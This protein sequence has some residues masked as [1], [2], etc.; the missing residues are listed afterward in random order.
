MF[1]A[2]LPEFPAIREINAKPKGQAA[3]LASQRLSARGAAD[4]EQIG[5]TGKAHA[6][7]H[8]D[9]RPDDYYQINLRSHG[10]V[11]PA[12]GNPYPNR[13]VAGPI[14]DRDSVASETIR[15]PR[16]TLWQHCPEPDRPQGTSSPLRS[17]DADQL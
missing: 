8:G 13:A 5:F 14:T 17:A 16:S 6:S 9:A 11:A 4:L 7:R 12:A 15:S 3:S 1:R 2:T 10:C